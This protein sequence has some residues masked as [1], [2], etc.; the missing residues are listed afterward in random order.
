MQLR[1]RQKEFVGRCIGA[2]NEHGNTL[3]IAPTG[4]GKTVMLSAAAKDMPGP[5]LVVQHRIELVQQNHKT[6]TKMN[7][8][9]ST[10]FWTADMKR[11]ARDG[12]T[13]GMI[14][15]LGNA[16]EALPR[17]GSLVIDEAHH[18]SANTYMR[19]V[20]AARKANPDVKILGVTATPARGDKRTLRTIFSNVADQISVRELIAT[21]HLVR[22][23]TFVLDIGVR[24]RLKGVKQLSADYDMDAVAA[25][26]D[27]T[28][29]NEK[30]V[31]EWQKIASERR[32]V[33]FCANVAHS[34]NVTAAFEAAGVK[35][36][37]IDGEMPEGERARI[38][39][40]FDQ[41]QFQV[42]VNVAV[43]TEG[44]DCQ[45]VS[46][47]VLLRPS[48]HRST[49]VQM[50]G[51][52]L[53]K[54]DPE[55][56]PGIVKDECLVL[57]F[58]TSVLQHGSIETEAS[59]GEGA[60]VQCHGCGGTVPKVC[61]ECPLCGAELR[62][63]IVDDNGLEGAAPREI[64]DPND[65]DVLEDF[66][67]TEVDLLAQSPYRWEE[68]WNGAV[69][70]A[71]SFDAWAAIVNHGGR[72]IAVGGA[73]GE[74]ARLL[75]SEK[76]RLIALATADDYMRE[77]S[78]DDSA[79][80]NKRW[81]SQPP[82]EKQLAALGY[83]SPLEAVGMTRYRAA[84]LMTWKWAEGAIRSRVMEATIAAQAQARSAA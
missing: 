45:P 73:K 43:L 17:L 23:R 49:M 53:R 36:A 55:R 19:L 4:A 41:G 77:R 50:V 32:T 7:P 21:G 59:M 66:A 28:V 20:D 84:C 80:K 56:Y 18:A 72:W 63:P 47:V 2:L 10:G 79:K 54:V 25:I 69:L 71:S 24:D 26:M 33:I 62:K 44:W 67:L 42:I 34:K 75:S 60:I 58:G 27:S 30:V 14:Q 40:A 6:F 38:L 8:G 37:H 13:F 82:S 64:K 52:G 68:L 31:E 48:S 3:G 12:W 1:P 51:R 9:G 70:I 46:C 83:K 35:A 39:R 29:L 57:D 81:L 5:G 11:F 16:G 74:R 22:P 15:S 76:E 78:D 61:L 65:K